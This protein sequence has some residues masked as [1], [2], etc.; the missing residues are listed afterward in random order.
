MIADQPFPGSAFLTLA[1][2]AVLLLAL[3]MKIFKW[4]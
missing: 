3:A 4:E 2:W 1:I